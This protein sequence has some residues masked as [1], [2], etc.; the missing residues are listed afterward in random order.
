MKVPH[1]PLTI[2]IDGPA[3]AGKSSAAQ[4]LSKRLGYLYL[5]TGAL[6]RAIAWKLLQEKIDL[7]DLSKISAFFRGIDIQVIIKAEKNEVWINGENATP[8]LRLPEV[9]AASSLISAMPTVRDKL[10]SVQR[11][12]G[13]KGGVVVEGRDTGTVV[14]P[15]AD[16][17]FFLDGDLSV[18]SQRRK[19][20]LLKQ[21]VVLDISEMQQILQ[22]R[23]DQDQNRKIA[24]LSPGK[25]AVKIDS[26]HLNL[27][28]VVEKML[29][30]ISKAAACR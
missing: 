19:D 27:N 9:S 4:L 6:Y 24:P 5:D 1:S 3:G 14:F 11:Q 26:S 21:G 15:N 2:T 29:A 23:D 12:F 7:E 20:D 13:E 28:E 18:R 22:S 30:V 8:Y 25:D 17:K 16:V 10:L